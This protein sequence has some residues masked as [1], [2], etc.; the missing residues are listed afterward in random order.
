V[1]AFEPD[2]INRARLQEHLRLNPIANVTVHPLALAEEQQELEFFHPTG[3]LNHG[4][5]SRYANLVPQ[6]KSFRVTAARLD[7]VVQNVPDLI[8]LDVEGAELSALCGAEKLLRS[9]HPPALIIEHNH[10]SAQ[11]AGYRPSELFAYLTGVQPRYRL[12]WIAWRLKPIVSPAALDAIRRQGN[13]LVT[14]G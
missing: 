5:A 14:V 8:K 13:L 2:P 9:A 6:G 12:F 10:E 11:A 3:E 7:E 4:Q 1:E